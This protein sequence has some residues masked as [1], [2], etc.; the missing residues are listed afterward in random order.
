MASASIFCA[1]TPEVDPDAPA[2]AHR[3]EIAVDALDS[4]RAE[5]ASV[6]ARRGVYSK[7]TAKSR[8]KVEVPARPGGRRDC[9][10]GPC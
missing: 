10:G 5:V 2:V 1:K 6:I 8:P 7:S 3:S 9:F 4:E